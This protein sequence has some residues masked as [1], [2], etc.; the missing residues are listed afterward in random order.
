MLGG[1][2]FARKFYKN[3][4]F[5]LNIIKVLI[6]F[7]IKRFKNPIPLV[8][9]NVVFGDFGVIFRTNRSVLHG[10]RPQFWM[11]SEQ[12]HSFQKLMTF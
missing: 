10:F 7:K 6:M 11:S 9:F 3:D 4:V 8:L 5:I 2:I 1:L 12:N